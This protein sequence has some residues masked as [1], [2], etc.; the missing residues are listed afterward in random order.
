MTSLHDKSHYMCYFQALLIIHFPT[1]VERCGGSLISRD[2]ILSAAH[3]FRKLAEGNWLLVPRFVQITLGDH[4]ISTIS[5]NRTEKFDIVRNKNIEIHPLFDLDTLENDISKLHLD[6]P[7]DLVQN[8]HIMPICLPTNADER[9]NGR[10]AKATGWGL[11]KRHNAA[12]V[13]QEIN[14]RIISM[15]ECNQ[16]LSDFHRGQAQPHLL[17]SEKVMCALGDGPRQEDTT[18]I[19]RGRPLSHKETSQPVLLFAAIFSTL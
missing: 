2:T 7:I 8:P 4:N 1:G 19:C 13:L 10:N 9:Y 18:R 12:E 16:H 17:T 11:T 6:N 15:G 5:R 14:I 3:C